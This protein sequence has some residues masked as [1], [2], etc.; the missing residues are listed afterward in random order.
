MDE[1]TPLVTASEDALLRNVA[2]KRQ[3]DDDVGLD[4]VFF[5]ASL[6]GMKAPGTQGHGGFMLTVIIV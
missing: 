2:G 5:V 1:R 4:T 3:D 6:V